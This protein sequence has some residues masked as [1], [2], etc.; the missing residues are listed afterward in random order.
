MFPSVGNFRK[1]EK[2]KYELEDSAAGVEKERKEERNSAKKLS[3]IKKKEKVGVFQSK[4]CC[5]PVQPLWRVSYT[6]ILNYHENYQQ[7]P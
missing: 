6:I 4:L 2:Y 7:Y 1:K 5:I 3:K